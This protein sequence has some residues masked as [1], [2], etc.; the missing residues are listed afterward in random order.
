M[1]FFLLQPQKMQPVPSGSSACHCGESHKTVPFCSGT[2]HPSN[3]S[4]AK[5]RDNTFTLH[6]S[7]AQ[8]VEHSGIRPGFI[9]GRKGATRKSQSRMFHF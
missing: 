9:V 1:A 5:G 8:H 6:K 4:S 2:K 7:L 3:F